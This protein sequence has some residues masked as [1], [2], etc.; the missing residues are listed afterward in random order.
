M[1]APTLPALSEA[2]LKGTYAFT[3]I[4]RGG[5]APMLR[6][7]LSPSTEREIFPARLQR[8]FLAVPFRKGSRLRLSFREPTRWTRMSPGLALST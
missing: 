2:S 1:V 5:A 6:S 8:I 3:S 4:G 7:A